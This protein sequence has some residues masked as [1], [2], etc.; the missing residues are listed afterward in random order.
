[1]VDILLKNANINQAKQV[2]NIQSMHV[3]AV[4]I[5]ICL[6]D[7]ASPLYIA[8]QKGHCD[9][10]DILLKNGAYTN[11]AMQVW[12]IHMNDVTACT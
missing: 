3:T 8:S 10:V 7:G 1:M 9:V 4:Y 2:W 5:I 6:Q 11:Q 12:T